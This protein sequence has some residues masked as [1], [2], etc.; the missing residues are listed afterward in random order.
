MK[1]YI[2]IAGV[3]G[4]GKT[5]LFPGLRLNPTMPRINTDEIVSEVGKWYNPPDLIKAGK[6][7]IRKYNVCIENGATFNQETTLCGQSILKNIRNAKENGYLIE[8]HYVGVDSVEIAKDRIHKRVESGG[9]GIPDKDVERRYINSFENLN[10]IML[11]IDLLSFYDN[12]TT[13]RRVAIYRKGN[14]VRISINPP[15]WFQE[16]VLKK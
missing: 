4:A 10:R 3:N 7:A 8:M 12:T 2:I 13:F 5:T 1:K 16:Y 6:I 15:F 11:E 14:K 9:H